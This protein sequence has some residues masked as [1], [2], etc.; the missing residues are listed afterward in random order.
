MKIDRI[1]ISNYKSYQDT[2]DIELSPGMNVI[3]GANNAG[4]TAFLQAV[5]LQFGWAQHRSLADNPNVDFVAP[6]SSAIFFTLSITGQEFRACA[7]QLGKIQLQLPTYPGLA[8]W[9]NHPRNAYGYSDPT[10]LDRIWAWFISQDRISFHLARVAHIEGPTILQADASPSHGMYTSSSDNPQILQR[11]TRGYGETSLSLLYRSPEVDIGVQIANFLLPQIYRFSAERFSLG[12]SAYG[13]RSVLESNAHNLAEVLNRLQSNASLFQSYVDLVKFVLPQVSWI[14]VEPFQN[15]NW[16]KVW[17]VPKET[18]RSDLAIPLSES[19]TGVGQVLAILYVA[20]TSNQPRVILIDEPQ[21][22]LHPGAS[23]RLIEVLKRFSHHQYIISTHSPSIVAAANAGSILI[24]RSIDG[25]THI[26]STSLDDQ[27]AVGRFFQEI[28][29]RLADVFGMDSVLWVEGATEEVAFPKL[30]RHLGLMTGTAVIGIR[31]TGDLEGRDARKIFEI[32]RRLSGKAT[33]L[34]PALA[35]VL[36]AEARNE[37][38]KTE[39]MN[40]AEG[41]LHF[42]PRRTFENYLLHAGAIW[43]VISKIDGFSEAAVIPLEKVEELLRG[44]SL[45]KKYWNPFPVGKGISMLEDI[46]G[47]RLLADMF[48]ELSD[49]RCSYRKTEHSVAIFEWILQNDANFFQN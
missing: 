6:K 2:G 46:D 10:I 1:R 40:M 4:K 38:Q 22:F 27:A 48:S 8:A 24:A 29:V 30:L 23:R 18:M 31:N 49:K 5:Q 25:R 45:E 41:L 17:S 20:M 44:K 35:F 42:L 34:P 26:E 37:Q 28:G 13:D 14:S 19:G 43:N 39:L 12:E 15:Q 36:D 32:Y 47:A 11:A 3:V 7:D 33:I 16:I 21:S 9:D